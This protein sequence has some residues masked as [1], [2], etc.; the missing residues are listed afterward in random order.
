MSNSKLSDNLQ[1]LR[2]RVLAIGVSTATGW[3]LTAMIVILLAG[4]WLDLVLELPP[5]LRIGLILGALAAGVVLLA[6]VYRRTLRSAVPVRLARRLDDVG[7]TGGRILSGIELLLGAAQPTPLAT[8]LAQI[9]VDDAALLAHG[10]APA[11]AVPAR[12]V[13]RSFGLI[14]ALCLGVAAL[15]VLA[16]RLV[17]TQWLRFSDPCGDH[18]PYSPVVFSVEP[19]DV[20]VMYGDGLDIR[21]KTEGPPVER[22]EVVLRGSG[23]EE[24]VL[25]MFPEPSGQ[26]RATLASVTQPAR[27]HVRSRS[28]RSHKYNIG[29][30]TV[31]RLEQA[32]FRVTPPEYTE[33]PAYEGP[34]PQGGLA[35]LPSTQV[36][37]WAKSNRTLSGGSLDVTT[38]Q[39]VVQ[40]ELTPVADE[41]SEVTGSFEIRQAGKI[42]F[43]VTDVAGQRSRDSFT[44]SVTLLADQRPFIRLTK[45]PPV[46]F[47]TP[48][49]RLPVVLAA[50]DDYGLSRLQLFRSLNDSRPLPLDVAAPVKA[51]TR[52]NSRVELPFSSYGL[53]PGDVI[54][55]FARVEDNDPAGAKGAESTVVRVQIISQEDFERMIRTR[56]GLEVLQSKYQQALRRLEK[57]AER[58]AELERE[59]NDAPP[60][61]ELAQR[62]REALR[63]LAERMQRDALE[64]QKAADFKL[65]YDVDQALTKE[66]VKLARQ[67]AK[68]AKNTAG[69]STKGGATAKLTVKELEKLR[70]MLDQKR[71][72]FNEQ[73]IE[74]LEHLAKIFPLIEDQSRFVQLYLRQRDLA[75]RLVSLK[76]RD[77]E[78]DPALK[79]RM[80]DLEAEQ[81]QLREELEALLGDIED[82]VARLPDDAQLDDLRKTASDF[83]E[84]LRD[85]GANEAMFDAQTGLSE[86]SGT[87]GHEGALKAADILE[88]FISQ[89]KGMGK[90]AGQCLNFNPALS[91]CLG[92]SVAQ[93]LAGAGMG[94]G[95]GGIGAGGG[96]SASRST[97]QN[98]GLYGPLPALGQSGLRGDASDGAALFGSGLGYGADESQSQ[99]V[100]AAAALRATGTSQTQIPVRYRRRVGHYF[101]RIAD[102]LGGP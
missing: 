49:V 40:S 31:P 34:L 74:P 70:E 28:A 86:F 7:S 30:I 18:P 43:D 59:L 5:R 22:V 37:L 102:E 66:L 24:E 64:I 101:Q 33:Q 45:P 21:V 53:S 78:D 12:S 48:N 25:P 57:L 58:I 62:H 42:R 54:K 88:K 17:H 26:W 8:G 38:G 60:E 69:L 61:S 81:V 47:A 29:V 35:G 13:G 10:V 79:A 2:R 82:H 75:E 73:V 90:S 41:P 55:L 14:A 77:N 89:C 46:S 94:T 50:E 20:R 87:R 65:P 96:Y 44:A 4:M 15:G 72:E 11:Q 76:G 27:Y 100:D 39:E 51:V 97:L 83:V 6:N 9:A 91:A 92:N 80:R 63:E 98:V 3:A 68:A 84:A 36:Q 19:R 67:L 99:E 56:R 52:V 16:P 1:T 93:M 85:S 23:G 32:R 95:F 71:D